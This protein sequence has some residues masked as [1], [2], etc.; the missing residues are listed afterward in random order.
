MPFNCVFFVRYAVPGYLFTVCS[1]W[2]LGIYHVM[3][4]VY[5]DFGDMVIFYQQILITVIFAEMMA[6]WLCIRYVDSSYVWYKFHRQGQGH[7]MSPETTIA[8]DS[9]SHSS[10]NNIQKQVKLWRE[11]TSNKGPQEELS[12]QINETLQGE[13][14][15]HELQSPRNS[16]S[17]GEV[18]LQVFNPRK[19]SSY[20]YWSWAPC[21]ICEFMRPPRCH[22]CPIC[23]VCVLKRDHH[24]Y[25]AGS[26]VGWRNQRHFLVFCVWAAIG[27]GYA[28]LHAFPFLRQE[29]WPSMSVFDLF[30]PVCVIRFLFGYVSWMVCFCVTV[31]NFLIYFLVLSVSFVQAQVSFIANG[32]TS[33]E[34]FNLKKSIEIRDSKT[35]GAKFRSV[36]GRYWLLNLIVPLHWK[37][38]AEED[39]ENW[40][41][42]TV[43]RH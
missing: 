24:C 29:L 6:N 7:N 4:T 15:V 42:I 27:A 13:F 22:H 39:P 34:T 21:Y 2:Y 18:K 38:L 1:S 10:N 23:Q 25:F 33:F 26:C 30:A 3:P 19:Q 36:L 37:I 17:K 32:L 31:L 16:N 40:P 11:K 28:I 41:T 20:P 43:H 8:S 14:K 35:L 9:A 12:V 5:K